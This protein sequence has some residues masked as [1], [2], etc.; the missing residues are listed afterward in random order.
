MVSNQDDMDVLRDLLKAADSLRLLIEVAE[1]G[2][3][4][5]PGGDTFTRALMAMIEGWCADYAD[6]LAPTL[7]AE[8][9]QPSAS[10]ESNRL[11]RLREALS[12]VPA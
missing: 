2:K 4:S 1:T 7:A 5:G 3:Q 12:A 9:R 11:N 6:Q 10:G 8:L